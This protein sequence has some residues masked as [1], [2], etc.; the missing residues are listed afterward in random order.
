MFPFRVE[1]FREEDRRW[2]WTT[3]HHSLAAARQALALETAPLK[4]ISQRTRAGWVVVWPEH[5]AGRQ[6]VTALD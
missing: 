2:G 3:K 6:S 1:V 5:W 4:R